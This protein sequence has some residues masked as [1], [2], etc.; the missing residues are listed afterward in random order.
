[1][2]RPKCFDEMLPSLLN[3]SY[4]CTRMARTG[5][6]SLHRSADV[7]NGGVLDLGWSIE[8]AYAFLRALDYGK[9]RVF[10][11]PKVRI[12]G[13]DFSVVGYQFG[14]NAS[15]ATDGPSVAV[16]GKQLTLSNGDKK[17]LLNCE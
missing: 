6:E 7:P 9:F 15:M 11:A 10:P 3:G 2:W 4:S 5:K 13:R 12:L 1:M 8:K 16:S 17:L 14:R